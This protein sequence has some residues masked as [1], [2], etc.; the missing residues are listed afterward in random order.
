[1]PHQRSPFTRWCR[2]IAVTEV[3]AGSGI[4]LNVIFPGP[5]R[6]PM[7]QS[8]IVGKHGDQLRNFPIA[9]RSPFGCELPK[10]RSG[11]RVPAVSMTIGRT[12]PGPGHAYYLTLCKITNT[13]R[14]CPGRRSDPALRRVGVVVPGRSNFHGQH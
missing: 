7:L 10:V 1:M 14:H 3:W 9:L 5:V 13:Q 8:Q 6:T 2:R 11:G 12:T 4:R